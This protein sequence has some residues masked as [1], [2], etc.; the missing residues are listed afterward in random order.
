MA[1]VGGFEYDTQPTD[2]QRTGQAFIPDSYD[3]CPCASGLK[4]KVCCKPILKEI[5]YAMTAAEEG[6][7]KEALEW[8]DKAKSW[9]GKRFRKDRVKW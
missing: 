8:M 3:L 6:N 2:E 4:Y 1:T 5:T 9:F 7:L